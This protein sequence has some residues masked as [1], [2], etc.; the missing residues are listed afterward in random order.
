MEIDRLALRPRTGSPSEAADL[1][2]RL[3]QASAR[4]TWA[5][6]LVVFLP[7]A[8]LCAASVQLWTWLPAL[9]LWWL[10]PWLDRTLLFVLA[11]AAFGVR[12]R[13]ADLW[14]AQRSVCWGQLLRTLTLRRLTA[15]RAFTQPVFQ[16]EGQRGGARRRRVRE[17]RRERASAARGVTATFAS[18]ETALTLGLLSL[19]LLFAPTG[20]DVFDDL[21]R[22]LVVSPVASSLLLGFLPYALAVAFLEPFYVAAGFGMYLGRR[23]ELEAWDLERELRH[24]FAP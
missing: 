8:A 4:D 15:S 12:T 10:K 17:L 6:Y 5:C 23:A 16:L 13:P 22:W 20:S 3:C 18:V 19:L 1:G 9:L 2:V 24:A 14:Q 11:R 21:R 7:V